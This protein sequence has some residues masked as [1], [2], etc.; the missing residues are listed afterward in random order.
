[1][2]PSQCNSQGR[3]IEK[4]YPS[5]KPWA[6]LFINLKKEAV[7]SSYALKELTGISSATC[8]NWHL[9]QTEKFG[10]KQSLVIEIN[11]HQSKLM[12]ISTEGKSPEG[13]TLNGKKR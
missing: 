12:F 6:V 13:I 4:K 9:L 11:L 5:Q 10:S 3:S 8:Y 2:M 1:M 7:T